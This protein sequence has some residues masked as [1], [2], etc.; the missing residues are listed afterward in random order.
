M[1]RACCIPVIGVAFT[2]LCLGDSVTWSGYNNA[3]LSGG[4]M[5]TLP[6]FP[7][8]QILDESGNGA[9]WENPSG[10]GFQM[11]VAFWLN[12]SGGLSTIN[13]TLQNTVC[14]GGVN[15][16]VGASPDI[17]LSQLSWA[18]NTT[19]AGNEITGQP[20]DMQFAQ[21]GA[22]TEVT[23]EAMISAYT[24]S[25]ELGW[26]DVSTGLLHPLFDGSRVVGGTGEA[27][28]LGAQ[29]AFTTTDPYGFYLI[30]SGSHP[31]PEYLT[32]S[33]LNQGGANDVGR[34]HF[35]VFSNPAMSGSFYVGAE[36]SYADI[37]QG[38]NTSL[39]TWTSLPEHGGDFN[40]IVFLVSP[41][42]EPAMFSLC[43]VGLTGL[44]LLA[45][46]R[47]RSSVTRAQWNA[48]AVFLTGIRTPP[49]PVRSATSSFPL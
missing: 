47:R 7:G 35:S 42:P 45:A 30:Y 27:L 19:T 17:P 34:Q 41:I 18:G 9:Y 21:S 15:P 25:S 12:G 31:D 48:P 13:S 8:S 49:R 23:L 3:T 24:S 10:D 26:Y 28:Q 2:C 1:R 32:N 36:D 37:G 20:E 16:C 44:A 6:G 46:R 29:A 14:V 4:I 39:D 33:T 22:T 11:S 5:Q 38:G 40:D 43:G